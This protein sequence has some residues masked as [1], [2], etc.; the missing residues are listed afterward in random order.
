MGPVRESHLPAGRVVA[1][2]ALA[3]LAAAFSASTARADCGNR[4]GTPT[5]VKT[6]PD[7]KSQTTFRVSWTN[8]ATE[9]PIYWDIEVTDARGTVHPQPAGISL[10]DRGYSLRV[11]KDFTVPPGETRCFRVKA[12][13]E[14]GTKGCV[15]LA[16]SNKAC[17]TAKATATPAPPQAGPWGALAADSAGH[18]GYGVGFAT[19]ASAREAAIKGCG[20]RRCKIAVAGQARCY[21]YFDSR[22][23]GYWYG[24]A[25]HTSLQTAISVAREG[26]SKG[27][28][29]GTC[30]QVK[31]QCG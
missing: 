3:A 30:K 4:P 26:C 10:G 5:N 13:T 25:L 8:R 17:A 9:K 31:A 18:W 7:A 22:S 24:L 23:R 29:A 21:A 6:F 1:S 12:R 27:A 16:W 2:L 28:P 14:A 19:E 20:N 15:S 11:G